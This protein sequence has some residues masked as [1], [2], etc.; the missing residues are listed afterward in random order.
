[1]KVCAVFDYYLGGHHLEYIHHLYEG[2][3]KQKDYNFIFFLPKSFYVYSQK[4]VWNEHENIQFHFFDCD[5]N[6][7]RSY[8]MLKK[9]LFLSKII[10]QFVKQYGLDKIILIET[11]PYLP[12]L[13]L[14]ISRNVKLT[15]IIYN[16]ARFR[17]TPSLF[18]RFLDY[19]KY[20]L[21]SRFSCFERVFLL[22]DTESCLFYNNKYHTSKFDY[23]P[24]PY[25]PIEKKIDINIK[26]KY[27]IP[28]NKKILLHFGGMTKRKG[29][30]DILDSI[31]LSKDEAVLGYCFIF[32]GRVYDDIKNDFYNRISKIGN[33]CQILVFDKFCEY[34]FLGALCSA[35]DFI[36][37]P[38]HTTSQSSG[39]I[40]YAAQ[41]NKPV[42]APSTGLLGSIVKNN[43]LGITLSKVNPTTIAWYLSNKVLDNYRHNE[44]QSKQYLLNNT[45]EKFVAKILGDL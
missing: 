16:I 11:M 2:A 18:V 13:P 4:L 10:N 39:V 23:L 34:D 12:F 25:F 17:E 24:D 29:S 21:I 36:L 45:V 33:K 15:S 9:S 31:L 42:I 20:I 6:I 27:N 26:E 7:I 40:A 41:Y 3:S 44:T 1:M 43:K 5:E 8:G 35:S 19:I 37:M 38:Y 30:L 22:N 32:A 14:V 28:K